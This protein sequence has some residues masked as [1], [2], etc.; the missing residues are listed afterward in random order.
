MVNAANPAFCALHISLLFKALVNR[1]SYISTNAPPTTALTNV[2]TPLSTDWIWS[3]I[4]AAPLSSSIIEFKELYIVP[5]CVVKAKPPR[6][7]SC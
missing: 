5:F 7:K 2:A 3:I 6:V 4:A 1:A